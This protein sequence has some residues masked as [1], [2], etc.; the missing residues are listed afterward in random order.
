MKL[1]IATY[2]HPDE[3]GWALH[4][5]AHI[6]YLQ[7]IAASGALRLSGPF[8]GTPEKAAMLILSAVNE[9][10]VRALLAEDP[11]MIEGLVANLTIM[12][13]CPCSAHFQWKRSA[14]PRLKPPARETLNCRRWPA[15]GPTVP[16]GCWHFP[17]N[18]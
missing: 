10:A 6:D 12:S 9:Q 5:G 2:T 4:L 14:R 17:A 16:V 13:G 7:K 1:F 3:E 18:S 8:V 11:Y 15:A